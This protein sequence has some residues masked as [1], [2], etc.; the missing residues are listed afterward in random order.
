MF[1]KR[2]IKTKHKLCTSKYTSQQL[3]TIE[4]LREKN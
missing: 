4:G 3:I 2:V 1:E